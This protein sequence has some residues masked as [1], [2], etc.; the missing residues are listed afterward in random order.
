MLLRPYS[1]SFSA[2]IV[3]CWMRVNSTKTNMSHCVLVGCKV[4]SGQ[5]AVNDQCG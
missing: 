1:F 5:I 3:F 2:Q 4:Q